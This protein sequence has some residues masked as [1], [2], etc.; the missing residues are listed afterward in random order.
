MSI[1]KLF[2]AVICGVLVSCY[3]NICYALEV[4]LTFTWDANTQPGQWTAVKIFARTST[5]D[6]YDYDS[7][8]VTIPQSYENN[9]SMPVQ[10]KV[11]FNYPDGQKASIYFVA[12]AYD[13]NGHTSN[14]SNE[15]VKTVDLVPL[16]AFDFNAAYNEADSS[17]DFSWSITDVRALRYRI[18]KSSIADGDFE[19][20]ARIDFEEGKTEYS[21]QIDIDELFPDGEETT[22]YFRMQAWGDYKI[23]SPITSIIPITIN[24]K[25]GTEV[26]LDQV[27]NFKLILTD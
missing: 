13:D 15:V 19:F 10:S 5:D 7:P 12:K 21:K 25:E 3:S 18:S 9:L 26:I 14:D 20:I 8:L 11:T 24:R 17:I 27:I 6:P 23:A 1:K 16:E 4:P 2:V 22:V